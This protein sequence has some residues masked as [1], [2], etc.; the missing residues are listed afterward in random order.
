MTFLKYLVEYKQINPLI[1]LAIWEK[2]ILHLWYLS[3]EF[4]III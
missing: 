3:L 2:T 1:S 4:T